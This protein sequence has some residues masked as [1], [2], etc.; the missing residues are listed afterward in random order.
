MVSDSVPLDV[1]PGTGGG[2]ELHGVLC[3][4]RYNCCCCSGCSV[5]VSELLLLLTGGVVCCQELRQ[6]NPSILDHTAGTNLASWVSCDPQSWQPCSAADLLHYQLVNLGQLLSYFRLVRVQG[7]ALVEGCLCQ[8]QLPYV[9][10]APC[11]G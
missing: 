6:H 9:Q 8:L 7:Q 2:C 5:R 10:I 1:A 3:T 4:A 11:K